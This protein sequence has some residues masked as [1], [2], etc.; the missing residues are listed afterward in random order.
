MLCQIE[1]RENMRCF[2][3]SVIVLL[4]LF[5]GC[6]QKRTNVHS[7]N[8]ALLLSPSPLLDLEI[9]QI[10]VEY[11][12]LKIVSNSRELFYPFDRFDNSKKLI[13]KYPFLTK[14]EYCTNAN[15][16]YCFEYMDNNLKFFL[17]KDSFDDILRMMLVSARISDDKLYIWDFIRVGMNKMD[18]LKYFIGED[19]TEDI[20]K[21]QVIAL[22][23]GVLGIW[24]YFNF[25]AN[26]LIFIEIKSDY[27]I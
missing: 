27:N 9:L 17:T 25:N 8:D 26:K 22:E 23:S 1:F 21:V 16:I 10:S 5:S 18:I 11:D 20:G 14:S 13:L 12:T 3:V 4:I 15:N 24:Y 7:I 2:Q 19:F 6:S